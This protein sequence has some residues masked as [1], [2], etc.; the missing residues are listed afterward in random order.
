MGL[1][2]PGLVESADGGRSDSPRTA[3]H[4]W[5]VPDCNP[6]RR[7]Y[8]ASPVPQLE[9]CNTAGFDAGS[10]LWLFPERLRFRVPTMPTRTVFGSS[11]VPQDEGPKSLYQ[12]DFLRLRFGY[13]PTPQPLQVIESDCPLGDAFQNV[14]PQWARQIN[15]A[16]L[17]QSRLSRRCFGSDVRQLRFSWLDLSP[18]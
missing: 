7:G 14:F 12:S 15:E 18:P 2:P 5:A 1:F 6:M 11:A 9:S 4:R 8:R 10:Y 16:D 13:H 17:Q 3:F